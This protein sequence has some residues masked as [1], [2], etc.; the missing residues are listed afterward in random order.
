MCSQ[1]VRQKQPAKPS[2][3]PPRRASRAH[4][5]APWLDECHHLALLKMLGNKIH[6]IIIIIIIITIFPSCSHHVPI[7]I[8]IS[9][10]GIGGSFLSP[11][12]PSGLEAH[13]LNVAFHGRRSPLQGSSDT[14]SSAAINVLLSVKNIAML[15]VVAGK[16]SKLLR[17]PTFWLSSCSNCSKKWIWMVFIESLKSFC[18]IVKTLELQN[19][20]C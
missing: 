12:A 3:P 4:W 9:E 7:S 17:N 8:Y 15:G 20:L 13:H 18:W 6:W 5:V 19:K 14:M 10:G 1:D 11:P 2:G 16:P